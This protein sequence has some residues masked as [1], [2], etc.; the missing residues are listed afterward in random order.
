MPA[1]PV[2]V[3]TGAVTAALTAVLGYFGAGKGK[4]AAASAQFVDQVRD[5][6]TQLQESEEKCRLQLAELRAELDVVR[7]ELDVVR[8]AVHGLEENPT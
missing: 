4:K 5:W 6:A 2:V 7:A 1:D 8:R 3:I